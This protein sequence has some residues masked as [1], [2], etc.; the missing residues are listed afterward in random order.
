[1]PRRSRTSAPEG[2]PEAGDQENAG[3]VWSFV[4]PRANL[5]AD[6]G[7][8]IV[9]HFGGPTWEARDGSRAVGRVVDGGSVTV[10]RTAIGTL[11]S[12]AFI[13]DRPSNGD[14]KG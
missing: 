3:V 5:Y 14:K 9:T 7:K 2:V 10:D 1:V 4:A 8:V 12:R 11:R 6:N 13:E